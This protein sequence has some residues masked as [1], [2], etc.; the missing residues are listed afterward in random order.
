MIPELGHVSLIIAFVLAIAL[1]ARMKSLSIYS[2]NRRPA[3]VS[4][5]GFDSILESY[6]QIE[7]RSAGEHVLARR[8]TRKFP[9]C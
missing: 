2:G 4:L 1:A 5:V 7:R 8:A 3:D 9:F 6:I